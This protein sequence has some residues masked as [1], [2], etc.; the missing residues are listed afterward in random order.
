MAGLR[1]RGRST[2]AGVHDE[3]SSVVNICRCSKPGDG[4]G[5]ALV[6]RGMLPVHGDLGRSA[7][8]SVVLGEGDGTR[9]KPGA[10]EAPI[11]EAAVPFQRSTRIDLFD[12]VSVS[13]NECA[14]VERCS[15]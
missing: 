15:R 9:I 2:H 1:R 3:R 14:R 13:W 8:R 11:F 4:Q 12:C 7:V 6:I 10:I 5:D